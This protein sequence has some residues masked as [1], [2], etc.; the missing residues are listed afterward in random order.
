MYNP[1][2]S[3]GVAESSLYTV[4]QNAMSKLYRFLHDVPEYIISRRACTFHVFCVDFICVGHTTQTR[5]W[6]NMGLS[7]NFI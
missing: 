5:F 4:E 1:P 6:W 7:F 2:I 3:L